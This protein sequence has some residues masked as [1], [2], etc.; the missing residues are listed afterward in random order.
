MFG[1]SKAKEPLLPQHEYKQDN[2]E[3]TQIETEIS[4]CKLESEALFQPLKE[5]RQQ[6]AEVRRAIDFE[7]INFNGD[8][9]MDKKRLAQLLVQEK[10]IDASCQLA[11][12]KSGIMDK[13]VDLNEQR[14]Q[15]LA[16]DADVLRYKAPGSGGPK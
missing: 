11:L 6:I 12:K 14:M 16:G 10:S 9:A 4:L 1:K 2:D 3:L 5:I 13:L 8:A 7:K 15:L